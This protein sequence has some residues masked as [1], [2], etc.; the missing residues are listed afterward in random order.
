MYLTIYGIF[1]NQNSSE[2]AKKFGDVMSKANNLSGNKLILKL[3]KSSG[4]A[5]KPR[6][7][8]SRTKNTRNQV[9][10]HLCKGTKVEVRS[11]EEGYQGAWYTAIVV[12][13][14]QNGKYLVEYLTLKTDDLTEQ[15]KEEADASDIRPYP[16]DI[17]HPHCFALHERVDAWYNDG[18]WVGQVSSVLRGFKYR[19]YFWLTKEE[20]EFE[21]CHLRPHQEWI[22]GRWVHL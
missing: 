18:W 13:S 17:N 3:K 20:L 1:K 10:L 11:D 22:D 6:D 7:V 8:T 19:V 14:M 4:I 12:D 5:K 16:P 21:H 15:L 9:V 2:L